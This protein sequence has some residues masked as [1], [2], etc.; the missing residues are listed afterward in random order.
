MAFLQY[1]SPWFLVKKNDP[2]PITNPPSLNAIEIAFD[3]TQINTFFEKYP[4]L[5][6]YQGD[7]EQLYRKHQFHYIWFDKDGLNEFA[8][9]LYNKLN[10][11]S[12]EGIESEVPYKEKIDDIYD[13]PDNNQKASIDTEL[14]SSALYF[15]YADK[16]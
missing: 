8:G 10:N 11:L 6:S 14:L 3:S 5:K 1:Y 15:F 4:K 7:V 12:L 16:V 13:N 2:V 9:L